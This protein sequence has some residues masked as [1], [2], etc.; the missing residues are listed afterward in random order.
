MSKKE[1][2]VETSSLYWHGDYKTEVNFFVTVL[3]EV[4]L[5]VCNLGC[6]ACTVSPPIPES[7]RGRQGVAEAA[8][9]R[10]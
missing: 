9:P 2:L 3:K 6:P 8:A 7:H 5:E 10:K 1:S 4:T